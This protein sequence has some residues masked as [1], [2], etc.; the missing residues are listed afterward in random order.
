MVYG[1]LV[2]LC[3]GSVVW[4]LEY[5]CPGVL[6]IHWSSSEP[7]LEFPID[8][9]F[10]NFLMPLAIRFYRPS[11]GLQKIYG[12]WFRKCARQLRLTS[13]LFGDRL[14]DEEVYQAKSSWKDGFRVFGGDFAKAV[15]QDDEKKEEERAFVRDGRLVRAPASDQ[16]RIPRNGRAFV[17]V[18]E[19]NERLDDQPDVDDG[20]HGRKNEM[21]QKV[22]VPPH[23]KI[24]VGIFLVMIWLFAAVTGLSV[25]IAP[26]L[27][28]RTIFG[29]LVPGNHR[30][31]DV[32]AFSIGI[33]ICGGLAQAFLHRRKIKRFIRRKVRPYLVSPQAFLQKAS[34]FSIRL[35]RLAYTFFAF[36]F[37]L[38][39]LFALVMEFYLV[40]PLHTY[41]RS[42]EHHIIHFIQDWTLGVLYIRTIVRLILWYA[43][44]RPAIAFT[45]IGRN[46]W[47]DPDVR[48]ATRA[49]IFPATATMLIA[50]TAPLSIGWGV[51]KLWFGGEHTNMTPKVYIYSYPGVLALL[52]GSWCLWM[53]RQWVQKWEVKMRDE[54]YLIGERLH[55]FGEKKA[56]DVAAGRRVMAN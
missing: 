16:V 27:L 49:F 20:P 21:Y 3:L 36:V 45:A 30:L 31:N 25:T 17:E 38:P 22:Y 14:E 35:A 44:S 7:V 42:G 51:N 9:L 52:L 12:W 15:P 37:L 34:S 13:F 11:K 41:F 32:Y 40:V 24:R 43:D 39:G 54:V 53:I 23:F 55:N 46:G 8:L 1:A 29:Y 48:L 47:L 26:L 50:I 56:R 4:G 5:A 10:Y 18:N 28:G 19:D 6:P 33:Y 2:I